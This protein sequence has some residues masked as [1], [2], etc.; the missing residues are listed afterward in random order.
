VAATAEVT[1]GRTAAFLRIWPALTPMRNAMLDDFGGGEDE[2]EVQTTL[3][4]CRTVSL[5]E[6]DE[7][8]STSND[9][10]G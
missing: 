5:D 8:L 6:L 2:V 10:N 4:S 9:I 3:G 1:A 7:T